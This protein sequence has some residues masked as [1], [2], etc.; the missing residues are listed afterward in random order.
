[1]RLAGRIVRV[2]GVLDVGGR[3]VI[4]F[5]FGFDAVGA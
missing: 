1:M 2:L 4:G 3:G 5:G